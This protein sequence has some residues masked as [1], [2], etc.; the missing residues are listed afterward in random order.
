MPLLLV[1]LQLPM[2]RMQRRS[3]FTRPAKAF[4]IRRPLEFVGREE[5]A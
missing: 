4:E 5:H 2:P 1:L 3:S